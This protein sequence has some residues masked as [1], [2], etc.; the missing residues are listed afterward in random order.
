MDVFA[1]LIQVGQE[2]R[3]AESNVRRRGR[4]GDQIMTGGRPRLVVGVTGDQVERKKCHEENRLDQ[5]SGRHRMSQNFHIS[6]IRKTLG[7]Q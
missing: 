3:E 2:K 6:K 5:G 7:K 1:P 4:R